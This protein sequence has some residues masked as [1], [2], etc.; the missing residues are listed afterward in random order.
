M[1]NTKAVFGETISNP[2]LDILRRR[3]PKVAHKNGVPLIVDNT[4]QHRLTAVYLIGAL[5]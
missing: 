3:L 1:P 2:S 5:Y 4:L